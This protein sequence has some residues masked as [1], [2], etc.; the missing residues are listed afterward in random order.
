M[1]PN[2]FLLDMQGLLSTSSEP[3]GTQ[4]I[5]G[6]ERQL[7]QFK[8]KSVATPIDFG[9]AIL[10]RGGVLVTAS[11]YLLSAQLIA[12]SASASS[13]SILFVASCSPTIKK[14]G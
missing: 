10:G 6:R 3:N 8:Q 13:A 14:W 1:I 4:T 7:V 12:W 9:D 11:G 5:E 2:A